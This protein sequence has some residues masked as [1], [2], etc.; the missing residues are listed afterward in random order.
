TLPIVCDLHCS[1]SDYLAQVHKELTGLLDYEQTPLSKVQNWSGVASQSPLFNTILNY[2]HSTEE[3]PLFEALG[4]ELLATQERSNYP[5]GLNVDNLGIGKGFSLNVQ[6]VE[7][8]DPNRIIE[9]VT[10]ALEELIAHI[11]SDTL[12]V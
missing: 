6:V 4:M 3:A 1:I 7:K 2:R 5:F 11:D 10:N 8:I 12:K 9:Y